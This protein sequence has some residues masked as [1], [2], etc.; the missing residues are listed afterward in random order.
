MFNHGKCTAECKVPYQQKWGPELGTTLVH[1]QSYPQGTRQ[2]FKDIQNSIEIAK[3][4]RAVGGTIRP[5]AKKYLTLIADL[6]HSRTD[7]RLV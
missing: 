4:Q 7:S 1:L 5:W 2:L 6:Q 3:I